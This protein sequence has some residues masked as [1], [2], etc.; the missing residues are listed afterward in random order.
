MSEDLTLQEIEKKII[1]IKDEI[2][3]SQERTQTLRIQL[4]FLKSKKHNLP[5][6]E[7]QLSY[8]KCTLS[9]QPADGVTTSAPQPI[10]EVTGQHKDYY[11]LCPD[12]MA[13]G[14]VRPVRKSYIHDR[15][16]GKT[17]MGQRIAETYAANP[18]FYSGTFCCTC[19]SHYP[20]G[21]DGEFKWEDG[22]R[23]GT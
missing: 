10:D 9:G 22:S 13:K 20:V 5:F 1:E 15:C 7:S 18:K 21:E 16:K 4:A 8:K 11:V 12:E 6:D 19:N 17:T 23:V 14:F 2:D 3:E